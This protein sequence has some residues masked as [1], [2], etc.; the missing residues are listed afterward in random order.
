MPRTHDYPTKIAS[1]IAQIHRA[2][3]KEGLGDYE[4]VKGEGYFYLVG[5]DTECWYETSI[6]SYRLNHMS[7][8]QWIDAIFA[9]KEAGDARVASYNS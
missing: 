6:Y 5:P 4:L 9:L 7:I 8:N 2:M 1:S 3:R